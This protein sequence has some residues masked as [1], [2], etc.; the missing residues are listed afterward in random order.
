MGRTTFKKY[1]HS[2]HFQQNNVLKSSKFKK[3][4]K[5]IEHRKQDNIQMQLCK[6]VIN[7]VV[8]FYSYKGAD[9]T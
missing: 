8:A 3:M 9:V 5:Y 2:I 1:E 6:A 7:Y 4:K